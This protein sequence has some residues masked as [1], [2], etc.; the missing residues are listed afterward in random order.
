MSRN[1]PSKPN[2]VPPLCHAILS[3]IT[4]FARLNSETEVYIA[5]SARRIRGIPGS[6]VRFWPEEDSHGTRADSHCGGVRISL[7]VLLRVSKDRSGIAGVSSIILFEHSS[8]V[9]PRFDNS[10]NRSKMLFT[11]RR[12]NSGSN[13][14]CG[15]WQT[16]RRLS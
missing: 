1:R 12:I 9:E 11:A 5:V 16:V 14:S 10:T 8:G 15:S 6:R 7:T 2:I 4:D 3:H 13:L